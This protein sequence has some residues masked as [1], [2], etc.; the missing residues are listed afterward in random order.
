MQEGVV[1]REAEAI[2]SDTVTVVGEKNY[3][4]TAV[5][6]LENADKLTKGVALSALTTTNLCHE[7]PSVLP[8]DGV[9]S[10]VDYGAS[11]RG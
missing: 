10:T 8:L 2:L 6:Y 11:H 7:V 3:R 9:L 5:H 4:L 1:L